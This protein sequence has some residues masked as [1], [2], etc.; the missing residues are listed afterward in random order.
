M[1]DT[2]YGCDRCLDACPWNRFATPTDDLQLQPNEE[3]LRMTRADWLGLT[4]EQYRRLFKGSAVKRAKYEGLMRNID[5][6]IKNYELRV[7]KISP[8]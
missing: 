7:K 3:L 1:G 2:V 6:V 5:C 8:P 4:V